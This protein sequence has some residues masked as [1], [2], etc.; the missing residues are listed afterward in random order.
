MVGG[1]GH[2][3]RCCNIEVGVRRTCAPVGSISIRDIVRTDATFVGS[4]PDMISRTVDAFI[5]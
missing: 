2:A 4:I 5:K 1:A 3:S